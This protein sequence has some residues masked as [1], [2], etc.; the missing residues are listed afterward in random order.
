MDLKNYLLSNSLRALSSWFL[1]CSV[2]C[3]SSVATSNSYLQ[4][5]NLPPPIN[6]VVM[7]RRLITFRI[8]WFGSEKKKKR[9]LFKDCSAA[10]PSRTSFW[11]NQHLNLQKRMFQRVRE[12]S[13]GY[14]AAAIS[15]GAF[16]HIVILSLGNTLLLVRCPK[17]RITKRAIRWNLVL[18]LFVICFSWRTVC[19]KQ[20]K[21]QQQQRNKR[22]KNTDVDGRQI[23]M[24]TVM[25]PVT[26]ARKFET[27]HSLP[28]VLLLPHYC[29]GQRMLNEWECWKDLLRKKPQFLF[30]YL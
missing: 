6:S 23:L 13:V 14:L 18:I 12:K 10:L 3:L 24:I 11:S 17:R 8:I 9:G 27:E 5:Q 25:F 7:H 29:W 19:Q 4:M 15:L 2:A 16:E 20:T 30:H 28:T 21:Q 1:Q 22:K 26:W